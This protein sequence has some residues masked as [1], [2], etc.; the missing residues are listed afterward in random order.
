MI[1]PK[2]YACAKVNVKDREGKSSIGYVMNENMN[3]LFVRMGE[4]TTGLPIELKRPVY[5]D[6]EG[7]YHSEQGDSEIYTIT[8][9][10]PL[11]MK[12]NKS[13]RESFILNVAIF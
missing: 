4:D 13:G 5:D 11:R 1:T 2:Y 7:G 12:I 3:S 8:Q 9:I 6:N 10:W